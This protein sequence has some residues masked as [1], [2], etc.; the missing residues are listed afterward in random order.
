[1]GRL[2]RPVRDCQ[3]R[4]LS[5]GQTGQQGRHAQ[6]QTDGAECAGGVQGQD[7]FHVQGLHQSGVP[8]RPGQDLRRR[9][10]P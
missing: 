2:R 9:D 6:R 8:V 5:Q 7:R 10:P 1:M 3:G 4:R